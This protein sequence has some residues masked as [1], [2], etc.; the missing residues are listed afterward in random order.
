MKRRF[1]LSSVAFALVAAP[2]GSAGAPGYPTQTI[3]IVAPFAAGGAVDSVGR[4]IASKLSETLGQPVII[5]N[6][7]GAGGNIGADA[8]AKSAP[9]G[10]TILLNTNGQAI[11]PSLYRSLPFDA[12][13]DFIP[14]TQ[15]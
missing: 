1:F 7:P 10:H 3:R 15:L 11:S 8:V 12:L 9:D 4:I 5:E 6:K 2:P 14:V 13:K